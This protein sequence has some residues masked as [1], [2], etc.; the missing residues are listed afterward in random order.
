[1]MQRNERGIPKTP[2]IHLL[3]GKWISGETTCNSK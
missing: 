2:L 3:E 1:M